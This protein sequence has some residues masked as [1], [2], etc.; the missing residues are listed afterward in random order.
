MPTAAADR[1]TLFPHFFDWL[2]PGWFDRNLRWRSVNAAHFDRTV[3]I[4]PSNEFIDHL[5]Q[6]KV[7]DRS[8]FVRLSPSDRIRVWRQVVEACTE[9]ADELNDVLDRNELAARLQPL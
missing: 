8:D 2:K 4:C 5:P 9:L 1:I 7:P 6:G 3:L